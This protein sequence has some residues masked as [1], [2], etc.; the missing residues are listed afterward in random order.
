MS[1]S[2]EIVWKTMRSKTPVPRTAGITS[3]KSVP[4][5][6]SGTG[7]SLHACQEALEG[8]RMT[9]RRAPLG[10]SRASM[11][12]QTMPPLASGRT[13]RR[14]NVESEEN[15]PGDGS[16]SEA[17]MKCQRERKAVQSQDRLARH[18]QAVA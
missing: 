16:D 13:S 1:R 2:F 5:W 10:V 12:A 11:I 3:L 14:S 9:K 15:P 17:G 18:A 8:G 6:Q 4:V 7:R